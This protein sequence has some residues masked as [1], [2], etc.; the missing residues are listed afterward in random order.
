MDIPNRFQKLRSDKGFSVYRLSKESD[1][2]ENYIHKIERGEN[3]PSV[4]ILEKLLSCLGVTLPEF[5]NEDSE[6][7][8]PSVFE[9]ELL[10][11]A[12]V[13]PKE[14]AQAL[15]QMAKLLKN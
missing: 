8:Y 12:R 2:S 4:Y 7:M 6:A 14:K 10:E 11:N 9:R 13:L 1:V 5:L 15:L 3:Q